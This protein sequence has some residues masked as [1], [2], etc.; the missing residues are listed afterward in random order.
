MV[1]I[2]LEAA[3]DMHACQV[4][5]LG[6]NIINGVNDYT[7]QLPSR[8]FRW[9]C[10]REIDQPMWLEDFW[11]LVWPS[12]DGRLC[13]SFYCTPVRDALQTVFCHK[14]ILCLFSSSPL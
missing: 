14:G 9:R 5:Y 2:F 1:W 10:R 6:V 7:I 8:Y 11:L 12:V 4:V 3:Q 13:N